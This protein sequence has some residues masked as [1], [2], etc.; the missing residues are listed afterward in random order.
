MSPEPHYLAA[1]SVALLGGAHC[2]GMCSGIV[3][4][5]TWGL[6]PVSP[7]WRYLAAYNS[8]RITSYTIAGAFAGGL[9]NALSLSALHQSQQILSLIASLFLIVL[10]G[11]ISGR[12]PVLRHIETAALPLWRRIEPLGRRWLPIRTPLQAFVVGMI[13]GW[14]PC[15]LVYSLLIWALSMG[16]ALS[17][18]LLMLSF[19]IGTLPTLMAMG[20]SAALLRR[21]LQDWRVRLFMGL[22]ISSYGF[23]QLIS[24][25]MQWLQ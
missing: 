14:L 16:H 25:V 8:G 9:G 17:G 18:A 11:Y 13:W 24:L 3:S 1:F 21:S 4:A 5:L 12:W 22:V 6:V 20:A 15:G 10:G 2:I 23:Y 7:P 19:G